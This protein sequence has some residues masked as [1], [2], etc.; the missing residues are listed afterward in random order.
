M[1]K[2]HFRVAKRESV[3]E[4]DA[5]VEPVAVVVDEEVDE[6]IEDLD[7]NPLDPDF[8]GRLKEFSDG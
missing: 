7:V 8:C 2:F 1:A 5:E 6:L 3:E 4:D